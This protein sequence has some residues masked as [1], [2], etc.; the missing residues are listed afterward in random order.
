MPA[1]DLKAPPLSPTFL[2][3]ASA[4]SHRTP[5]TLQG[6]HVP[7]A[8]ET[9]SERASAPSEDSESA[10]NRAELWSPNALAL[11]RHRASLLSSWQSQQ[12][13]AP[14]TD[15]LRENGDLPLPKRRRAA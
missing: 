12:P 13:T 15:A 2:D 5:P 10:E 14:V 9:Y 1:E 4:A 7:L 6:G 3:R 11:R 8:L